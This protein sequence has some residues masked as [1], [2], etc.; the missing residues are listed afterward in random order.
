MNLSKARHRITF[1]EYKEE[2][3]ENGWA[4]EDWFPIMTVWAEAKTLDDR[5]FYEAAAVQA[6]KNKHF[7]IRYNRELQQKYD[8]EAQMRVLFKEKPYDIVSLVNVDEM[9]KDIEVIVKAVV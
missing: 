1:E 8:N 7:I 5:R 3:N 2:V 6:E 9:N 4:V